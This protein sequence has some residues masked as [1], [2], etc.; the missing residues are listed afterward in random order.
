M[1]NRN[2]GYQTI[3]DE[4]VA[5]LRKDWLLLAKNVKRVQS[6][7]HIKKLR[8]AA[9]RWGVHL[10]DLFGQI[11]SDIYSRL[12]KNIGQPDYLRPVDPEWAERYLNKQSELWDFITEIRSIPEI[13][14]EFKDPDVIRKRLESY[15][16]KYDW[17]IDQHIERYVPSLETQDKEAVEQWRTEAIKWDRRAKRKALKAWAWLKEFGAWAERGGIWGGGE[18]P[19]KWNLREVEN[20]NIEG[21]A[22]QIIGFDETVDFHRDQIEKFKAGLRLYKQLAEQ[23]YPW[24][25]R[26]QLPLKAFFHGGPG[27]GYS[28]AAATYN[29]DH[30][31]IGFWAMNDDPRGFAKTMAHEMGHHIYQT[32]LSQKAQKFWDQSV[33]GD[34]GP[35][36]LREVL[37]SGRS[38][39]SLRDLGR[40]I[41][42]EN[43]VLHLKLETFHYDLRFK[44]LD[45]LGLDD[46]KEALDQGKIQPVIDLPK[47]PI[48]GYAAK[49]TEEAFCETLGLLVAYGPR[50]LL[51]DVKKRFRM[52]MP[53]VKISKHQQMV[54]RVASRYLDFVFG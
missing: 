18:E 22:T 11:K 1:V 38:D 15:G 50:A 10:E 5:G 35:L 43:P 36:D 21:F 37:R 34:W 40:R 6:V 14:Y 27:T 29:Y 25:I 44:D 30:I 47:N 33:R 19:A 2:A 20:Q 46:I 4:T 17:Q 23:R 42:R 31:Q 45:I 26:Y 52:I 9:N 51:S 13:T 49:N 39:E 8:A 41:E 53:N 48:T 3:N 28:N 12:R 54:N 7:E 16:D 32:V 24:L